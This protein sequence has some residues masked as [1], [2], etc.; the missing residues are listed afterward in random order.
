MNATCERSTIRDAC[1]ETWMPCFRQECIHLF[2]TMNDT[3]SRH[4]EAYNQARSQFDQL[5]IEEKAEFLVEAML[6][7]IGRGL[8]SAGETISREMEG[9]LNNVRETFRNASDRTPGAAEGATAFDADMDDVTPPGAASPGTAWEAKKG[10]TGK[11]TPGAD[12]PPAP[13]A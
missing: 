3:Q 13:G 6:V 7:T 12:T 5:R 1:S 8:E 9:A 10:T 2:I 11:G 4:S